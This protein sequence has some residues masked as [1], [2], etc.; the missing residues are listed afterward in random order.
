MISRAKYL[1]LSFLALW[2]ILMVT[3]QT[4]S[5]PAGKNAS[6]AAPNAAPKAA[7]KIAAKPP[8][9][10]APP[11][12]KLLEAP[13]P[14]LTSVFPAGGR[15]G[16]TVPAIAT[17]TD[18]GGDASATSVWVSGRAVTGRVLAFKDPT[19]ANIELTIAPDAD[20]TEREVRLITAGGVSNRS[21]FYVGDIPELSEVEPNSEKAQPQQLPALPVLVNGQITDSDRDY[22]RF[23]ARAGQELVL[24]VLGRAIEPF[25]ANAV[26]G[27]FDPCLT[28][29]DSNGEQV[30]YADDFRVRPDPVMFFEAPKEG[31]Y[32]VEIR[33][34]IY[35]GRPDF[36]YRLSIGELPYVTD[37]FPLGGQAGTTAHVEL[38]GY[39][40]AKNTMVVGLPKEPQKLTIQ[41]LPFLVDRNCDELEREPNDTPE[42]AQKITSPAVINGRI[43]KPG[44]IDYYQFRVKA[45]EKLVMEV[46][47]RRLGSP[48][49]SVLTLLDAK[50]N[51]L[52]ENDDWVDQMDSPATHHADSRLL[53]TFGA[54]GTYTLRLRDIQGNGG[55]EY[56]YRLTVAP[57]QPDF[58]LRIVPDNPRMGQGDTAAITV[59]AIRKD[60]FDGEIHL[61]V[62]GLPPGFTASEAIIQTGQDEGRLTITAPSDAPLTTVEPSVFGSANTP[63]GDIRHRAQTAE[64]VMQAF[65]Y[66]HFMPTGRLALTVLKPAAYYLKSD[67]PPGKILEVK[68]DSEVSVVIKVTRMP[69]TKGTV[70]LSAGRVANGITMKSIFLPADKDEATVNITVGNDAK[71]G[72][73][74]NVIIMGVLKS[75]KETITRYLPA[76]PDQGAPRRPE[77]LKAAGS[78]RMNTNQHESRQNL[79]HPQHL[80]RHE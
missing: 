26:P 56:A 45:G 76:I 52:A 38:H 62:E 21:R 22:F 68:Q 51:Q 7:P 20:L 13:L 65:A 27:W 49:D 12:V 9:K 66:T 5:A 15:R 73:L 33:D 54:A 39:N 28:V 3:A 64:S 63:K 48:L 19:H 36:I 34:I 50:G 24:S 11:V 37:I 31:D 78:P 60:A 17:G 47:A 23:H 10:P 57:P 44:D 35:R 55:E 25:I 69:E 75:G 79:D 71:P 59:T 53:Y 43:Q 1:F 40:L 2:A 67:V 58:M 72:L 80:A 46:M 74:Q 18:L 30:A 32:T 77:T 6:N 41:G 4:S 16:T 14:L 29:F 42:T 61:D 8:V 70:N